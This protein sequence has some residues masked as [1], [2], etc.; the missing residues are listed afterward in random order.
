MRVAYFDIECWDLAAPFGPLLCASVYDMVEKKMTTLRQDH[1]VNKKFAGVKGVSGMYDD[2]MLLLDLKTILDSFQVTAGWFSKG[3]DIPHINTRLLK[4]GER[5]LDTK[6]HLDGIWYCKGWRGIKPQSSKLKHVAEFFGLEPKP[7]VEPDVWLAART[8][9][10]HA[11]DL[12]CE[13]CESDVRITRD[14][15]EILLDHGYVR[16]IQRY[17]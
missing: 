10:K 13:R 6:L 15:I 1:Y 5:P 17:P 12:V 2:H 11:M 16:N 7:D 4:W 14:A 8:G 9:D 3:F